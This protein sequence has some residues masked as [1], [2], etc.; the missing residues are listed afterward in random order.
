[1]TEIK[2]MNDKIRYSTKTRVNIY[3]Y[4]T[5]PYISLKMD[6]CFPTMRLLFSSL[7]PEV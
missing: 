6:H 1:M 2:V 4:M 7:E 5:N 3:M